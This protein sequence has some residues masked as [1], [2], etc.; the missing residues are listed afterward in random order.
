MKKTAVLLMACSLI[1]LV[2][3]AAPILAQEAPAR[4]KKRLPLEISFINHAS[5][6]PFN[7]TIFKELHP[8]FSLGTEY[9][10]RDGTSGVI[11]QN[12]TLG[13]Y[14][15]KYLAKAFFLQSSG[16]YRH[17]LPFGLFADITLGMGYHL[18]FH[19]GEVF[20]LNAEGEYEKARSPGRSALLIL[21][22]VGIGYDFTR[23]AGLPLS[24]F[25]RYQPVAQTPFSAREPWWPHALLHAGIRLRLW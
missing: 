5:S 12:L 9:L 22:S 2:P 14:N 10:H 11:T 3:G 8:G 1:F 21:A 24:L 18:S 19:P 17:T 4:P 13:Y 16:G 6:M 15:N 7:G 25:I 23:R 20:K